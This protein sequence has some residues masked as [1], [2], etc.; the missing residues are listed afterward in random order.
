MRRKS[1]LSYSFKAVI[2]SELI[3]DI[4]GFEINFFQISTPMYQISTRLQ[5]FRDGSK[6]HQMS[7]TRPA[8]SRLGTT[9]SMHP[10]RFHL[11]ID[12]NPSLNPSRTRSLRIERII[13]F[14][15]IVLLIETANPQSTFHWGKKTN[16]ATDKLGNSNVTL[17]ATTT[18]F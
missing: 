12:V 16:S 9:L 4:F 11:T 10:S 7:H 18:R 15:N 17:I 14:F 6:R 5:L 3:L 1:L 13:L 8:S 2:A